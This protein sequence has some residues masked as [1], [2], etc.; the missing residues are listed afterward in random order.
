MAAWSAACAF[1]E[2]RPATPPQA[3]TPQ[4][5]QSPLAQ[6][7]PSVTRHLRH[8]SVPVSVR[9]PAQLPPVPPQPVLPTPSLT[10]GNGDAKADAQHFVEQAT[11]K[12]AKTNG[13]ALPESATSSYQ[14]AK[15]LV[16]AAQRALA[17]Q[18]YAAASSL[19]QKASALA[20]ELPSHH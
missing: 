13:A 18:D 14:Q 17:D 15:E 6:P 9:K 19:A 2:S 5:A 4:P 11:L 3:V 7:S 12:L 10:L 20:D 16:G 1:F 8:R